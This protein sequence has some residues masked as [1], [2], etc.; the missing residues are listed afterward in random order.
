MLTVSI[1]LFTVTGVNVYVVGGVVCTVC[2]FYT[3]LVSFICRHE[4][5]LSIFIQKNIIFQGGIKAV[6]H[7]DAWQVIVMFISVVVVT[8]LGTAVV[9]GFDKVFERAMEGGRI[10]LFKYVFQQFFFFAKSKW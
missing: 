8:A 7:T 6:V 1:L 9:G 3:I 10:S 4:K 5:I 2:V